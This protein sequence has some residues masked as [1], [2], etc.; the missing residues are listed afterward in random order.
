MTK[1]GDLYVQAELRGLSGEYVGCV[2]NEAGECIWTS[3]RWCMKGA[4]ANAERVAAE[5]AKKLS[6]A[7]PRGHQDG[8]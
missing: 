1:I 4:K 3:S 7:S 6:K 8:V 5:K 2:Y